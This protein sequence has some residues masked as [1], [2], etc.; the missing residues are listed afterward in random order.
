MLG[1]GFNVF[2]AGNKKMVQSVPCE[3]NSDHTTVMVLAQD[4]G[5]VTASIL[6][7]ELAWDEARVAA[8]M[9]LLVREGMAWVDDQYTSPATGAQERAFW[10]PALAN[11]AF[12]STDE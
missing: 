10:F 6:K 2:S 12:D 11:F 9:D 8:V 5:F 1:C 7:K 4:T 3:L